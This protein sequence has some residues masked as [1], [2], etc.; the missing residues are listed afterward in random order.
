MKQAPDE[1]VPPGAVSE[2]FCVNSGGGEDLL[3]TESD[4]VGSGR[5]VLGPAPSRRSGDRITFL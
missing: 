4:D 5:N 3:K 1:E 2:S